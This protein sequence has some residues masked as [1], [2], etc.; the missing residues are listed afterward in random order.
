MTPSFF[1]FKGERYQLV[2]LQIA[3]SDAQTQFVCINES[4]WVKRCRFDDAQTV[5]S[6]TVGAQV[7][8][9]VYGQNLSNI[10]ERKYI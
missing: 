2:A 3:N 6:K 10:A 4:K 7:H 9:P 8:E 5:K 1:S